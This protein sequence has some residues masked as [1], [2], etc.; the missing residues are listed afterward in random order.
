[1]AITPP[2]KGCSERYLGCHAGCERYAE[3][4]VKKDKETARRRAESDANEMVIRACIRS[5]RVKKKLG[6]R[7]CE[8]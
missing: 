8:R 5:R 3:Y 2:C 7:D 4:R 6:G 1:M